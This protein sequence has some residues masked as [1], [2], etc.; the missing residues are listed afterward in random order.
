MSLQSRATKQKEKQS[1]KPCSD[2]DIT[3]ED[4]RKF[5]L[6]LLMSKGWLFV[7]LVS[8]VSLVG[9]VGLVG[10]VSLVSLVSLVAFVGL[11]G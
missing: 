2:M 3:K 9:L 4:K 5:S 7:S 10:L 6:V 8:L 11:V 1:K